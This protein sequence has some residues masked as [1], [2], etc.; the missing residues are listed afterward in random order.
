MKK[1]RM[2]FPQWICG[3][4]DKAKKYKGDK[5]IEKGKRSN[6]KVEAEST[7]VISCKL[8]LLKQ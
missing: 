3:T 7:T 2:A 1:I 5:K 6:L 4:C 8:G